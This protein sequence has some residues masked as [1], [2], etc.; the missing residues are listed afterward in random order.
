MTGINL[1][2][3]SEKRVK[4]LLFLYL[5]YVIFTQQVKPKAKKVLL[6]ICHELNL[7]LKSAAF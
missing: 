4:P 2:V 6:E 1:A 3:G 5:W 7:M